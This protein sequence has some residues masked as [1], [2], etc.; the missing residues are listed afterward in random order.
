MAYRIG[1][2]RAEITPPLSVPYLGISPRHCPFT[3]VH[4]PLWIR[5]VHLA[6]DDGAV[7]II[8]ADLIGLADTLLGPG[9]RFTA[10][11]K[12][13][14][15]R[16]TG[17]APAEILLAAAH[18]HS[19]PDTLD[20]R[21]L[22]EAPGALAWLEGLKAKITAA[23]V[24]ARTQAFQ[25]KL[26]SGQIDFPGYA[27][28][29]RHEPC[30]DESVKLLQFTAV[31][32]GRKILLMSYACH[33]VIVQVQSLV[34]GDFV[35]AAQ[36]G[37]E[38]TLNGCDACLFLQGASGD[39]NPRMDDSRDFGDVEGFGAALAER[40]VALSA[41]LTRSEGNAEPVHLA[42]ALEELALPSR[43]LPS[44][45]ATAKLRAE[46]LDLQT[47]LAVGKVSRPP[48]VQSERARMTE[49]KLARI[50]EGGGVFGAPVQAIRVGN[51]V[52]VAIPGEPMCRMGQEISQRC[53][54]L[55]GIT[56]GCANGYLGYIVSPESWQRGGYE[57]ELGPWSKVGP[58]SYR[59]ILEAVGRLKAKIG[60]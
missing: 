37:V 34:S 6:T 7:A 4:D 16:A 42:A 3:G 48:A 15:G 14:I 11:I 43:D 46:T 5:A 39:I 59:L 35:G 10:E 26:R 56:V 8:D 36:R 33:P 58:E 21:P 31:D 57:V 45:E 22:R 55:R 47:E 20:F 25:A 29:R 50:A 53:E 17:L 23:V 41:A 60:S 13:E 32:S 19:T 30:L 28:N 12:A 2:A 40:I 38:H 9:R 24:A 44:A 1:S 51:S 18:I 27:R 49:E 52:L 54:P